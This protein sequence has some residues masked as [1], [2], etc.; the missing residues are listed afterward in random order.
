MT[1]LGK[2]IGLLAHKNMCH[3]RCGRHFIFSLLLKMRGTWFN[4]LTI[5]LLG[6]VMVERGLTNEY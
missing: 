6:L 4:D 1:N 2:F 3:A 5:W